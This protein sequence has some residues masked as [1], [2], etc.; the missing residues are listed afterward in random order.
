[1]TQ[2]LEGPQSSRE[3]R[4]KNARLEGDFHGSEV[5]LPDVTAEVEL[6]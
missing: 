5:F 6:Q 4:S 1:M 2:F 3:C